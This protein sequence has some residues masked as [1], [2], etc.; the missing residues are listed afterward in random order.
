MGRAR[1][2]QVRERLQKLLDP[3]NPAAESVEQ[4][5]I[6]VSEVTYHLPIKVGDFSDFSCSRDHVLNAGEAVL[7]VR[8]LPPGFLHF[9]VGYGGRSSSILAPESNVIRPMGQFRSNDGVT[10]GLSRAVDFELEVA[11]VVGKPSKFGQPVKIDEAD[12]HIFGFL[13]LNDWSARDIQGLEMN[14]LGPFNGKSFGTSVSPWVVTADALEPYRVAGPKKDLPGAPYL[15]SASNKTHYSVQLKVDIVADGVPSTVC[16]SRLEWLYWTVNEMIAHQTINGCP[17]NPGDIL[18]T[19]TV[20]GSNSGTYGCLLETTKGGKLP[21]TL[22]SGAQ[23]T[24]LVDGDAV[25]LT[26]FAGSSELSDVVGFGQCYGMLCVNQLEE[27]YR[28]KEKDQP[29]ISSGK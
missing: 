5:A 10:F 28:Q 21:I 19:G 20:S 24:Y 9:P 14:P 3:A 12:E 29:A 23:R 6:P 7:G 22:K 11:C 1:H 26:G 8:Q 27:R 18:A 17:L 15:R 25:R 13:L 4:C 2:R 16:E